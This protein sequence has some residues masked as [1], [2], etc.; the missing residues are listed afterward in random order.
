MVNGKW[1][2]PEWMR[3]PLLGRYE[4]VQTLEEGGKPRRRD[5]GAAVAAA[6]ARASRGPRGWGGS[7][8]GRGGGRTG[9][10]E[11]RAAQP[12]FGATTSAP[13]SR[14][15]SGAT[16]RGC[17]GHATK[18]GT[19]VRVAPRSTVKEKIVGETGT[20]GIRMTRL[21]VT[22]RAKKGFFPSAKRLGGRIRSCWTWFF[23]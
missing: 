16:S 8:N 15:R 17:C 14:I 12:S 1:A 21:R 11:K 3:E 10:G 4:I 22:L 13:A 19:A 7:R 6:T 9:A 5:W 23:F 18:L 20:Q 2:G